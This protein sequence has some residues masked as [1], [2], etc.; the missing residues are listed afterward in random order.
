[1]A[2]Y[3]VAAGDD[4]PESDARQRIT[5]ATSSTT[6]AS[7]SFMSLTADVA[8]CVIPRARRTG[9]AKEL[10]ADLRA[11]TAAVLT[12]V[13]Q[14]MRS[15]KTASDEEFLV[16]PGEY[17]LTSSS[18]L[19]TLVYSVRWHPM[20]WQA[21]SSRPYIA[22]HVIQ[23]T[24]IPRLFSQTAPYDVASNIRQALYCS[25]RHPTHF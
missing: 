21:I 5:P 8:A 15:N 19:Q 13:D 4:F 1:M 2:S 16:G 24:L 23:R 9:E 20:T 14:R 17:R 7:P 22:R 12:M 6:F 18:A 3:D 25:P 10:R 11:L